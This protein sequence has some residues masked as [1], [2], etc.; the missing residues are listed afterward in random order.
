LIYY[1]LPA[2][3]KGVYIHFHDIFFPFE[4]PREWLLE[5]R[6][7]NEDYM[8][9]AFLAYNNTFKIVLF[10]TYL[11]TKYEEKIKKRF[12]LLYKN[13]GGSIWIKKT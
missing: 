7:W 10:N 11:E 4:Y 1:I 5:G 2:L 13:T 9:R 6:A 12:P 8:L 3:A